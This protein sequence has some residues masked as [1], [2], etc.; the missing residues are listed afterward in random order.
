[1]ATKFRVEHERV[2]A[3]VWIPE[4]L[5]IIARG[6]REK[7]ENDKIIDWHYYRAWVSSDPRSELL[8]PLLLSMA[9]V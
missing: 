3:N 9:I 6:N 8:A 2:Q 7:K 1:M 4:E 5:S